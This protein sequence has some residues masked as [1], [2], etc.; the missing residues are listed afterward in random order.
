MKNSVAVVRGKALY[1][2]K[3]S[4]FRPSGRYPEYP[5]EEFSG[6]NSVYEMVRECF[7][8]LKMDET[9][10]GQPRWNPLKEIV[11]PGDTVLIK[12][13]MV[14]HINYSGAGEE[15]LYTH[16]SVVAAV[17]DYVVIALKGTGKIIIAD[18]PVQSCDFDILTRQSGYAELT[19]YYQKKGINISLLDLRNSRT[20]PD[21]NMPV[22]QVQTDE[23]EDN[24]IV[25][26]LNKKSF[27]WTGCMQG[28]KLQNYML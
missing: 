11:R 15:C 3:E 25:V 28:K 8:L 18:A 4:L 13:N 9:H 12:P 24:G 7:H 21:G 2:Q 26:K 23:T 10:F 19:A 6:Q 1:P 14:R 16:P 20:C 5:F 27:L 22:P 17:T